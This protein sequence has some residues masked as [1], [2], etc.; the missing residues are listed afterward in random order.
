LDHRPVAHPSTSTTDNTT[1]DKDQLQGIGSRDG[2]GNG[3]EIHGTDPP[4]EVGG[5]FQLA[6]TRVFNE[7]LRNL[8]EFS[9]FLLPSSSL[10]PF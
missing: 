5:G 7:V 3:E 8:P 10:P 1:S 2:G 6:T 4:E 9:W